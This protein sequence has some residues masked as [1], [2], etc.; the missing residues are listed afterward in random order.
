L[1]VAHIGAVHYLGLACSVGPDSQHFTDYFNIRPPLVH[2]LDP[3]TCVLKFM[4]V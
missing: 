1:P 2:L 3:A 4:Q